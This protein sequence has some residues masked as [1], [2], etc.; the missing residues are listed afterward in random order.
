MINKKLFLV[1]L[2][3]L[4]LAIS[5]PSLAMSHEKNGQMMNNHQCQCKHEKMKKMMDKLNLTEQQKKEMK[6]IKDKY[7]DKMKDMRMQKKEMKMQMYDMLSSDKV[8]ESKKKEMVDK[9]KE[10]YGEKNQNENGHEKRNDGRFNTR[11]KEKIR[12][13][14]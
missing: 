14:G 1:P 9:M 4:G 8:D 7:K 3:S 10:M 13:Y 2:L 12:I 6:D 5:G 11:A